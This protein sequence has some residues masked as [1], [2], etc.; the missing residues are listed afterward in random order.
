MLI[1]RFSVVILNNPQE[2]AASDNVKSNAK[3]QC[4]RASSKRSTLLSANAL[5]AE[6]DATASL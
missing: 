2:Q 4:V 6:D 5:L 3:Y 1:D